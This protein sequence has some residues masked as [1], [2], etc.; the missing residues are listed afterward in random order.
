MFRE[1]SAMAFLKNES[2]KGRLDSYE[3]ADLILNDREIKMFKP[4]KRALKSGLS[5]R[6]QK[7][8]Q[9]AAAHSGSDYQ[10]GRRKIGRYRQT[11]VSG[12][13]KV[14]EDKKISGNRKVSKTEKY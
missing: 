11:K 4:R 6:R 1:G 9:S 3:R 12:N 10:K 13:R 7:H 2:M 8:C 14:S 5:I